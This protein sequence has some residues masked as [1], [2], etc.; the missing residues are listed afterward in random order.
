MQIHAG[1]EQAAV[2]FRSIPAFGGRK[3]A[4]SRAKRVSVVYQKHLELSG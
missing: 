4:N 1:Q 3:K 2:R